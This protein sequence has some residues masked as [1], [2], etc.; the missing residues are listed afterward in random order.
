MKS[1]SQT[2][3]RQADSAIRLL[4][5][6]QANRKQIET[7]PQAYDRGARLEHITG[8][9]M[10]QALAGPPVSPHDP[11]SQNHAIE[12]PARQRAALTPVIARPTERLTPTQEPPHPTSVSR[13]DPDPAK[14]CC[15]N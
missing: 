8:V 4:L 12:T 2:M 1:R 3:L 14:R 10:T 11:K 5:R 13:H 7:N 9:A 15:P 6:L